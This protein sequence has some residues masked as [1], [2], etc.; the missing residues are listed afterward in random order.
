MSTK[1]SK[2]MMFDEN[3]NPI[4]RFAT[5]FK[6]SVVTDRDGN[7]KL[8]GDPIVVYVPTAVP[9]YAQLL[10]DGR[11]G[12]LGDLAQGQGKKMGECFHTAE[13]LAESAIAVGDDN[14]FLVTSNREHAIHIARVV[15]EAVLDSACDQS[16]LEEVKGVKVQA[17][18]SP[19]EL[20]RQALD[21]KPPVVNT[22]LKVQAPA[23]K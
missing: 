12:K 23:S 2:G 17:K 10:E 7:K 18:L 6:K 9:E 21:R 13:M 15:P 4:W 5:P 20:A 11:Q 3:Q 8:V 19:A 14:G 1:R 22:A 16:I